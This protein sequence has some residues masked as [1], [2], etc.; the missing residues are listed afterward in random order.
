MEKLTAII[1]RI[2]LKST[3]TSQ[4]WTIGKRGGAV[5][6]ALY[7]PKDVKLPC[8]ITIGFLANS[9]IHIN[10]KKEVPK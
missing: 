10:N 3:G 6:G 7:L 2:D 1:A 5:S 4:R 9:D 8:G